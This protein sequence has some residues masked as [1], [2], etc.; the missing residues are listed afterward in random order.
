VL[1]AS[2]LGLPLSAAGSIG[3]DC[4]LR[5]ASLKRLH[6]FGG[7]IRGGEVVKFRKRT[8]AIQKIAID[9]RGTQVDPVHAS[10]GIGTEGLAIAARRLHRYQCRFVV[11]SGA[12]GPV[13]FQ[14]T[15]RRHP[16]RCKAGFDIHKRLTK[17]PETINSPFN[18]T[19]P[20]HSSRL[21]TQKGGSDG[22]VRSARSTGPLESSRAKC[23]WET[24]STGPSRRCCHCHKEPGG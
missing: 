9:L 6:C 4:A 10:H 23:A 15:V 18:L 8:E 14:M 20:P 2:Q 24:G 19:N 21:S 3:L 5:M 1:D 7:D 22:P 16:A 17:L 12:P 13:P 11:I